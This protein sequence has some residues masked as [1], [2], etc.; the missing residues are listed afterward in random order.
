MYNDELMI[1]Y[2]ISVPVV[3]L[4][5]KKYVSYDGWQNFQ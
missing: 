3:K 1:F 4:R 2:T 5:R